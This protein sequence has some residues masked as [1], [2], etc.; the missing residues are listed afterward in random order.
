MGC[1]MIELI[2]NFSQL[3]KDGFQFYETNKEKVYEKFLEPAMDDFEKV[4]DNYLQSMKSYLRL[5]KEN[6]EPFNE[7]NSIFKIL[8]EDSLFSGNLREKLY[9]FCYS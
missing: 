1:K 9:S 7:D 2:F 5:I 8:I 3:L 4:H 6:N